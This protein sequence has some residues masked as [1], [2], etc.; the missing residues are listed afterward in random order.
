MA[1]PGSSGQTRTPLFADARHLLLGPD[2]RRSRLHRAVRPQALLGGQTGIGDAALVIGVR[3][4]ISSNPGPEGYKT[5]S[6]NAT[7]SK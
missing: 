1:D 4:R 3:R 7:A 2:R 6:N 5:I